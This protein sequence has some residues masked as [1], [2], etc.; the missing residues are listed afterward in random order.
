MSPLDAV[1]QWP[2]E[3]R[4]HLDQ[5]LDRIDS[6]S[7]AVVITPCRAVEAIR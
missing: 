7:I 5:R 3:V 4:A 2:T 1:D 6:L